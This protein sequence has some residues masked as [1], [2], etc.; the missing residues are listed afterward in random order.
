MNITGSN[1][2][3]YQSTGV[4]QPLKSRDITN[5]VYYGGNASSA[6]SKPRTYE[7]EYNQRNND[8]KS[9]TIHGRMSVGNLKLMGNSMNMTSKSN[10]DLL[11]NTRQVHGDRLT[12]LTPSINSMGIIQGMDHNIN[13][14]SQQDRNIGLHN[15]LNDNPYHNDITNIL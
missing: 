7:A 4:S 11:L 8:N 13:S 9:S 2:G 6:N 14:K 1:L 3:A 15:Q 5:S 10:D 12:V